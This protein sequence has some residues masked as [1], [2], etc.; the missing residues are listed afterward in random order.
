MREMRLPMFRWWDFNLQEMCDVWE[1]GWK[2]WHLPD[3]ILNYVSIYVGLNGV[4]TRHD[5]Q[6]ILLE[7]TGLKD[8]NGV[9]IYEGDII[10][11]DFGGH[12]LDGNIFEIIYC[13]WGF[14]MKNLIT[15]KA[16]SMVAPMIN[17]EGI[18][19]VVDPLNTKVIGNTYEGIR[20]G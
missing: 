1:I 19:G 9:E 2:A 16:Y 17:N 12:D 5:G 14:A 4:E 7:F 3:N 20:G 11:C 8:K 15:Y 18:A 13:E 6:G 10:D